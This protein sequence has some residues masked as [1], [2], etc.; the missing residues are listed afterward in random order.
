[1]KYYL[2]SVI[3]VVL[4]IIL[5][6]LCKKKEGFSSEDTYV[7]DQ[8]NYYKGRKYGPSLPDQELI[9]KFYKYEPSKPLGHQLE[10]VNPIVSAESEEGETVDS[11]IQKCKTLKNCSELDNTNCGYCIST[12]K[13]IYGNKTEPL[14]DVCTKGWVFTSAECEEARE[15]AI[16]EKVSSCHE[17]V[18]DAAIC[19]WCEASGKAMVKK[20]NGNLWEPKYPDK[21]KCD[22]EGFGL[23][24][25]AAG[26]AAFE[27]DHPCIGPNENTGP[28][29]TACLSKLWKEAG[30]S[31]K[32]KIAP[33][34]PGNNNTWWNERGWQAT[35]A[36]MK[37]W[38]SD[39]TSSNW[40]LANTHQEGC[41]GTQPDPCDPK[42]NP[43]PDECPQQLFL[44]AGCTKE[45]KLY[46]SSENIAKYGS[47]Y[48]NTQS[49]VD[50]IKTWSVSTLQNY[51]KQLVQETQSSDYTT[52]SRATELCFGKQA[53]KPTLDMSIIPQK[54][55][56][57]ILLGVKPGTLGQGG[58]YYYTTKGW[59]SVPNTTCCVK[60]IT[61][62]NNIL[63]GAGNDGKLY[64][65]SSKDNKWNIAE[66]SGWVMDI[67]TYNNKIVGIGG[68]QP[69]GQGTLFTWT[70]L[71]GW[72]EIEN[73]GNSCCVNNITTH[74]NVLYGIGNDDKLYVWNNVKWTEIE[75][76]N[77]SCCIRAL[78]SYDDSLIG[79]GKTDG[80]LWTWSGT[81]WVSFKNDVTSLTNL[82]SI[83]PAQFNSLFM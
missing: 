64:S 42:Y 21:D 82:Y 8:I 5:Y 45:G 6:F 25:D 50:G 20:Q 7:Q 73:F 2:L 56:T 74:N 1:M 29:S 37:A 55:Q 22:D 30:C 3:L 32:G 77:E 17:M 19:G 54:C 48:Y 43:R 72:E 40:D 58:L 15:R 51:F 12:N 16:C 35:F 76:F 33:T 9:D 83:T 61:I 59:E 23:V 71:T 69:S 57:S 31:A 27:K 46:P 62:L 44:N 78:T 13:F 68:N 79:L 47:N 28:H 67:T 4:I 14:T 80:G 18:G 65:W 41:L 49:W 36:D 70:S 66:N 24:G 53:T 75:N 11:E 26:C 60:S 34:Q 39:A 38:F 81:K 63:Y 10:M 52:K